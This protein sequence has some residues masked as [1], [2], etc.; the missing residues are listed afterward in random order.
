MC[1][2]MKNE[3]NET[4]EGE[5]EKKSRLMKSEVPFSPGSNSTGIV[6]YTQVH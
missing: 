3:I 5:I 1:L 4:L 6:S 2:M